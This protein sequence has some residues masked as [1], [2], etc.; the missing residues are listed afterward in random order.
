M[1]ERPWPGRSTPP[2]DPAEAVIASLEAKRL[3][4]YLRK[5]LRSEAQRRFVAEPRSAP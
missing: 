3:F 5:T 4:V 2:E 1:N